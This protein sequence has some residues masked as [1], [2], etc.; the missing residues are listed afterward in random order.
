MKKI[1]SLIITLSSLYANEFSH[2][3]TNQGFTGIINTPNAQVMQYGDLTFHYDNQFDNVL[4]SYNYNKVETDND[5]YI[6]GVGFF[7]YFEIQ[8]RLSETPR[9]HRDL[10]ANMKLQLPWKYKYLPNIA[11]GI[12]DLGSAANY[13]GDKY[14][15]MDKELWGVRA[16]VGYGKSDALSENKKRMDGIFGGVEIQTFDWL[17][18]LA[19]DDTKER[20]A[21]LRLEL[22][23]KYSEYFKLNSVITKNLST[24]EISSSINLTF[25]LYENRD[26]YYPDTV[27]KHKQEVYE[28]RKKVV[29]EPKNKIKKSKKIKSKIISEKKMS[30][31]ELKKQ[32]VHLGLENIT[33]GTKKSTIYIGYENSVFLWNDVDALGVVIGLLTKTKYTQFVVAQKRSNVVVVTVSGNLEYAKE[34]FQKPSPSSKLKFA[35]SLRKITPLDLN[36]Y[37]MLVKN[38]NASRFKVDIELAPK[39]ISFVGTEFGV[40]NYKLWLRTKAYINLAKGIDFTAVGDIHIYD[41]EIDDH[42]YDWFMQLYERPSHMESIMIND[43]S[44]IFGGINTVSVGTLEE[45][46]FGGVDQYIKNY[47]NHTFKIKAGYFD[48]FANGYSYKERYYGRIDKRTFYM[49]TYSYFIENYDLLAEFKFGKYWN[50][51]RGYEMKI[52]SF[53]G[54]VAVSLKYQESRSG[55]LLFAEQTNRFAGLAIEIPLT[56]RDTPSFSLG[57]I[58]GTKAFNYGLRTTILRDDGTNNIVSGGN[59]DP[60]I[61]ITSENYFYNRNRLQLSYIKSHLF[62]MK[63]A[64]DTYVNK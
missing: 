20:F 40:F 43:S 48:E 14:V 60:E 35:N 21:G 4:R 17:Y 2:T 36:S 44:N 38:E 30:L 29:E 49:G 28:E 51:D 56:L 59:K 34:F 26:T 12:Q 46:Y 5:N 45:N 32:L 58:R 23:K 37:T 64:F 22:P 62:R 24:N 39:I 25:A 13:Y 47:K 6:F 8:G 9:Y 15:V 19:E 7:P 33:I 16:S 53:F 55:D 41:S 42:R 63:E 54:D 18:L 11:L 50:Q 57:Q 27:N 3:L 10:S 31:E 52:K 61:A 1:L